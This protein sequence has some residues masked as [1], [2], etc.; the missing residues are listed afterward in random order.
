MGFTPFPVMKS[1]KDSDKKSDSDPII[2]SMS[3]NHGIDF[4]RAVQ[5][6]VGIVV[7]FFIVWITLHNI[8]HIF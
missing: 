2:E 1:G 3:D 7:S 6:V 8:L 4:I 5:I